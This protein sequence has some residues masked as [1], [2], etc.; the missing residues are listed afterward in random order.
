[1]TTLIDPAE[2]ISE[3]NNNFYIFQCPAALINVRRNIFAFAGVSRALRDT[4]PPQDLMIRT[5][6]DHAARHS[7][8]FLKFGKKL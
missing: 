1:M 3:S 8:T 2:T 4:R 5:K 7:T 6:S